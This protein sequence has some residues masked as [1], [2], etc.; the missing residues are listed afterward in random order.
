MIHAPRQ[1]FRT[2]ALAVP[3]LV[4]AMLL[5]PSSF[6]FPNGPDTPRQVLGGKGLVA[7][8]EFW[9]TDREI[10]LRQRFELVP[11]WANRAFQARRALD[12]AVVQNETLWN[13]LLRAESAVRQLEQA[14]DMATGSQRDALDQQVDIQNQAV[15]TK[16]ARAVDPDQL[17]D[18]P[19]VKAQV[20]GL[21]DVRNE[22]ALGLYWIRH[23]TPL[24]IEEYARLKKD[25]DVDRAMRQMDGGHRLGP[26]RDYDQQLKKLA[27]YDRVV[28]SDTVP[29]YRESGR[30]R[31]S[32][33]IN[34]QTP[35]TFTLTQSSE[36]SLI[37]FSMIERAGLIIPDDSP[38]SN[39][40]T[41][42]GREFSVR[43]FKIPYLRF[44]RHVLR[45]VPAMAL[46]PEGEDLG[47]QIGSKTLAE[48]ELSVQPRRLRM[49]VRPREVDR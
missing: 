16:R 27:R 5:F 44:G 42:D 20:I 7:L 31:T 19:R 8:G 35:A 15:A 43:R 49:V 3:G 21:I 9:I 38:R 24:L 12:E 23:A 28:H 29:S 41:A 45:D 13:Q 11:K 25:A 10:G 34:D 39:Y 1:R 30:W 48:Y 33:L 36:S 22:L 17:A 47:A 46:P 6:S 37:P 18:V 26:A 2:A 40:C 4:V 32:G 14:R